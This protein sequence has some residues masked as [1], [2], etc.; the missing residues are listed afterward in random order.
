MEL[1]CDI[2]IKNRQGLSVMHVAAQADQTLILAYFYDLGVTISEKDSKGG[3]PLHWAAYQGSEVSASLLLSWDSS[4]IDSQDNEGQ[5]P[6]HLATLSGSSRIIRT[7]LVKGADRNSLDKYNRKPIDIA[8]ENNQ[9]S[10]VSLLKPTSLIHEFGL[11]PPLRPPKPNYLSVL[12]YIAL[13]GGGSLVSASC[14]SQFLDKN[15]R[16]GYFLILV[17][18]FVSFIMVCMK[19]P[20]YIENSP[21]SV[22]KLYE[23]YEQHLVCPDCKIYRPVRSRHC[24]SCDRCVEKFD[25]HCPWVNNCIGARNLGWFF[26][27]INLTWISLICL[28]WTCAKVLRSDKNVVGI[29]DLSFTVTKYIA[30]CLGI[31]CIIFILPVTILLIVHCQN[32]FKNTTTSERFGKASRTTGES[33]VSY[34]GRSQFCM[35]NCFEMCCNSR[36][37]RRASCEMRPADENSIIYEELSKTIDKNLT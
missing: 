15:Y 36:E 19:N 27:F 13:Y 4:L 1:G 37:Y 17:L 12:M 18:S 21:V 29:F 33:I 34:D 23:K 14:T 26:L 16:F 20:G 10:L 8:R 11:R 22:Y 3:I 30:L 32:F 35:K 24:Q 31:F 5:T 25:H 6:L 28:L 7:L 2:H 9:E